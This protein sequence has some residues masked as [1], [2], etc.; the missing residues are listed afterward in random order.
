MVSP[1]LD[2][3]AVNRTNDAELQALIDACQA[4]S[5]PQLEEVRRDEDLWRAATI[6]PSCGAEMAENMA[7]AK[8]TLR[9]F[10]KRF[11][12]LPKRLA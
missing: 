5:G 9:A 1:L 4:L 3:N 2:L 12:H 8:D 7:V 11:N 10:L 6:S